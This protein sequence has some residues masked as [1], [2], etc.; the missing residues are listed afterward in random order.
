MPRVY[1]EFPFILVFPKKVLACMYGIRTLSRFKRQAL[2]WAKS[3]LT[4]CKE[5]RPTARSWQIEAAGLTNRT[6]A[7]L[8][9]AH[10][11]N[12]ATVQNKS[13]SSSRET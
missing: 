12:R 10:Y 2:F 8:L 11:Q 4:G 13:P 9:A 5:K 3:G 1:I 6:E 7:L